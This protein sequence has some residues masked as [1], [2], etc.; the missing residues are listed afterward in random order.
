MVG[1]ISHDLRTPLNGITILL[2]L[3]LK[4]R[5]IQP[6]K[7]I[8]E[9]IQPALHNCN[10]L[11]SLINDILDFTQEEFNMEP[12]MDYELCDLRKVIMSVSSIF[13][14]KA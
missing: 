5:T 10:H 11:L 14:M 6:D 12:K 8:D 3:V 9:F 4:I 13:K 7:L 2:N 1:S